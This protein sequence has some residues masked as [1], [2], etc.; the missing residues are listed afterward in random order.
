MLD[1][2]CSILD[3]SA[4]AKASVSA[5]ATPDRTEDKRCYILVETAYRSDSFQPVV[6]EYRKVIEV[7]NIIVI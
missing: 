4:F 6:G 3:A 7:Y 1:T 5:K 2:R